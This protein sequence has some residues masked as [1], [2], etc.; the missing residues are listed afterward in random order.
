MHTFVYDHIRAVCHTTRLFLYYM[1]F[2]FLSQYHPFFSF[3]ISSSLLSFSFA[4]AFVFS[5][6]LCHRSSC[7]SEVHLWGTTLPV[8]PAASCLHQLFHLRNEILALLPLT[9]VSLENLHE[10]F[11]SPLA[12]RDSSLIM[13][14][15]FHVLIS[16]NP[17]WSKSLRCAVPMA[18]PSWTVG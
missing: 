4:F 18:V 10:V 7:S 11:I 15:G 9:K 6:R 5:S 2:N 8:C 13:Q 1:L 16:L 3:T 17:V 14:K 12:L